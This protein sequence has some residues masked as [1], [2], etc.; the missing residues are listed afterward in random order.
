MITDLLV[1]WVLCGCPACVLEWEVSPREGCSSPEHPPLSHT[2]TVSGSLHQVISK[3]DSA[4]IA[5]PKHIIWQ[6]LWVVMLAHLYGPA[7]AFLKS[8]TFNWKSH[9]VIS[10]WALASSRPEL[11]IPSLVTK[12]CKFQS[13]WSCH[14]MEMLSALLAHC[15][16]NPTVTCGFALGK[17]Q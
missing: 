4:P 8:K 12:Y 9:F 14:A 13:P 2:A 11:L 15:E 7:R 16:G 6:I 10:S 5:W 3:P 17:D 1:K